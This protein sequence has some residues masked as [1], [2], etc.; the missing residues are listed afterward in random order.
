MYK[1]WQ[2]GRGEWYLLFQ[3]GL[4]ALVII[5]P[6]SL[7]AVPRWAIPDWF[8]AAAGG[9]LL[10]LG[11]SI[12][13]AGTIALGRNLTPLPHPKDDATLI[14]SGIY[15]FVRHPIY[16]GIICMAYGFA[17][18]CQSWL[19]LGYATLLL[20]FFELKAR[21]E[22]KWLLEK[23]PGYADYRKRVHRFFPYLPL[24]FC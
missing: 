18:C 13:L 17:I 22:E 9:S 10:L 3:A 24:L 16:S 15:R 21:Q 19:T 2:G 4:I 11:S 23:F 1:W 12:A 6:Q 8:S 5:G 7:P 14:V 20:L